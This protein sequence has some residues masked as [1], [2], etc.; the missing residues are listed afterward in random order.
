MFEDD[1]SEFL[2][3]ISENCRNLK[4]Q[5]KLLT[6][7]FNEASINTNED[8]LQLNFSG[9]FKIDNLHSLNLTN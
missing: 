9:S 8:V 3:K 7:N 6:L 1:L 4:I 5:I 2:V